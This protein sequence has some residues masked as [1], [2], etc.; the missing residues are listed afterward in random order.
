VIAD[1][2]ESVPWTFTDEPG[3]LLW[4]W[5]TP[6]FVAR[7]TGTEVP[8]DEPR[9]F[10]RSYAW[11]LADLVRQ[12]QGVPRLLVDGTAS[13]FE[14]AEERIRE[15]VGKGYDPRLGYR[16]YAGPLC[17][18]FM[19]STGELVDVGSLVGTRCVVTVLLPDRTERTVSGEFDVRGYK[20]R[21]LTQDEVL[22]IVPEHV[23]RVSNRSEAA[24]RASAVVHGDTYSG[25]GR[26]YRQDPKPGCTGRAGFLVGTVDHAGQPQCPLHEAG[27]PRHLLR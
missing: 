15:H 3:V 25:I 16:P 5:V 23:V 13:S 8:S 20:W 24:E 26:I 6:H 11:S 17:F 19:L 14:E 27:I 21:L 22:E 12:I 7:I 10:V 9:R 18:R 2:V 4:T 1:I